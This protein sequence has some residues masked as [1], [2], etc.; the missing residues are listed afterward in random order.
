MELFP[1]PPHH[2]SL[3]A[4]RSHSCQGVRSQHKGP[5][6]SSEVKAQ[7]WDRDLEQ[8][9]RSLVQAPNQIPNQEKERGA[10]GAASDPQLTQFVQ[11]GATSQ[12]RRPL[13]R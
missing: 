3:R 13:P 4:T 10:K 2:Q 7:L 9:K 8:V 5:A 1:L 11:E 12:V 6:S